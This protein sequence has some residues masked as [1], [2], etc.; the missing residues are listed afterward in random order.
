MD[1]A[2]ETESWD[3]IRKLEQAVQENPFDEDPALELGRS[4]L[5]IIPRPWR[6]W[7]I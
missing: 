4:Y 7:K 5:E 1:R 3:R 6:S 2:T